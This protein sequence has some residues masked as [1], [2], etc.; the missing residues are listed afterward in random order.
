MSTYKVTAY[1]VYSTKLENS[2]KVITT[3]YDAESI[4]EALDFAMVDAARWNSEVVSDTMR[5]TMLV[6]R[7]FVRNA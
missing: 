7:G 6:C 2:H 1:S 3:D 4:T 5:I